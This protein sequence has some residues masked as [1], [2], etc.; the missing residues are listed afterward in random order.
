MVSL[1]KEM[2]WVQKHSHIMFYEKQKTALIFRDK[3]TAPF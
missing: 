1:Q 3:R 2:A